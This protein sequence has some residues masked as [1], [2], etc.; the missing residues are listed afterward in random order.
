MSTLQT[1]R[2][3]KRF[4][5]M[6]LLGGLAC[7]IGLLGFFAGMFSPSLAWT[8]FSSVMLVGGALVFCAGR[9]LAWWYHG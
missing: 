4:K 2:T 1:E 6:Q 7:F 3:A 9:A 5:L 8:I